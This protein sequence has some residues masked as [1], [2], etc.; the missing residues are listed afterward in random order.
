MD[1]TAAVHKKAIDLTKLAIEMTTA[2]GAGHP[3]SAASLAHLVTVLMYHHMRYD[4]QQPALQNADRLVLSEGHACPIVYA[5]AADLGMTIGRTPETQRAMTRED[6]LT[7]RDIHSEIDGH[8]NPA[9][10]FPFF[11]AATGSLGQGL[12]VAA[13]L[14][15]AARLDESDQRIFCLIGDGESREG[16]I[17]EA[18]DFIV[19][20]RL[21]AVCPI[22]NCNGHG[23]NTTVSRQQSPEVTADKLLTAGVEAHIIDGHDPEAIQKAL[24][25]HTE[26]T[27]SADATPMAIVAKTTKGWGFTSVLS[28]DV[29]GQS[30]PPDDMERALAAL[31][32][33][34]TDLGAQPQNDSPFVPSHASKASSPPPTRKGTPTFEQALTQF[35][36]DKVISSGKFATRKAY[37]VALQ[38][39]GHANPQVVALDGDVYNSTYAQDFAKDPTLKQRFFDCRIAEQNMVSCAGGLAAGGKLPFVS[40]FGKFLTRGYDQLEMNLVSRLNVKYVGS[41]TGVSLASDGPSQMALPDVAFFRALSTVQDAAGNPMM[42]VLNPADAYAAYAL[43]LAMAAHEGPC[44]MRTLRPDVAFL[45]QETTPFTLGGHHVLIEGQALLV[46]AAGYMV[47]EAKSA[48]E[49]LRADG[50]EATLVDFYS[51]PFDVE[52]LRHLVRQNQGLVLTVEDN[53]GASLGSAVAEAL[54]GHLDDL[55]LRQMYVRQIPKSGRTPDDVLRYLGLSAD[56]IFTTALGMLQP[57]A[58]HAGV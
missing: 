19:D 58:Q 3:T 37:G 15:L 53:Y 54:V 41:H 9:E 13:G 16:Q 4:P 20:Q 7:L 32:Q 6:A 26:R 1:A 34:A 48:V 40:T 44:Y 18:V 42:Y 8:P 22:F 14:A 10:G 30:V 46:V 27:M 31:D 11:A 28:S 51:L 38:A 33:M 23:Q 29:H 50:H 2:A 35:G 43:T 21:T 45:Y 39:L 25:I 52:A 47:H 24:N 12:S 55:V 56:D 57:S 49:R 5:A 17:W 36:H